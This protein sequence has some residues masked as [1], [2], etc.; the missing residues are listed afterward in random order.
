MKVVSSYCS[1][2]IKLIHQPNPDKGK[3]S[4]NFV[5]LKIMGKLEKYTLVFF[6]VEI[7]KYLIRPVNKLFSFI[8][9]LLS[10]ANEQI[11]R[12]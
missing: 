12:K 4:R 1:I 2:G 3:I 9:T 7:L 6:Q 11:L 5:S 10:E 8:C